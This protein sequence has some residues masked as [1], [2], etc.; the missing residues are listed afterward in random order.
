MFL[1]MRMMTPDDEPVSWSAMSLDHSG[2]VRRAENPFAFLEGQTR[3]LS[4]MYLHFRYVEVL[5]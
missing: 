2:L 5:G 4:I 3:V 1:R